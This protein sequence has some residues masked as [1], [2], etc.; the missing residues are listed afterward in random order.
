MKTKKLLLM[1]TSGLIIFGYSSCK[2]VNSSDE[3]ETTF[4]LSAKQAISETLTEDANNILNETT[5][6]LGLSGSREPLISMG[7]TSCATVTVSP[8]AFP[9]TI[10]LDFGTSG[11][12]NPNSNVTRR[13]IITIVVSDSIRSTGSTA[14]MT[15]NNY[16][17]N[18][19]KKEGTITWTN[20]STPGTRSWTRQVVDGK[21]T[22][23][24]GRI[25]YHTSLKTITQVAGLSTP[26]ILIDDAYS[27]TGTATVTNAAGNTRNSV[28]EI[29]LHKQVI[30]DHVD[31]GSVRFQGAVHNALLDYG[32]G[33]CDNIA[34]ISI[35]GFTPRTI[36]LP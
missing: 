5:E 32:N 20:I 35:D 31:Q 11:C 25:W 2:K 15:F 6:S 1:L 3:I 16:Y 30:C 4:D 14:V 24:D 21:I 34:T 36:T 8:G 10:T 19:Y 9:K 33:I 26:R 27:I 18:N 28:I 22:A 12:T 23:P 13:G 17:V 29:P 7:T